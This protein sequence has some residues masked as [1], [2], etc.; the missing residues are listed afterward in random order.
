MIAVAFLA[1]IEADPSPAVWKER[2]SRALEGLARHHGRAM[3]MPV[4]A[5]DRFPECAGVL[6]DL[7]PAYPMA[8]ALAEVFYPIPVRAA[9]AWGEVILASDTPDADPLDAPA[10][11][12]AAELLY[13]VRKEDRLLLVQGESP[14]V[15]RL[16]NALALLLHREMSRWTER[17]CEIVRRYR[18]TGRQEAVARELGVSQQAVSG[19]LV[20]AGWP[21]LLE[22]EAALLEVCSRSARR[23]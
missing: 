10:F 13:R 23:P 1:E 11:L 17:Q 15:D 18:E 21:A 8:R 20:A 12:S 16:Q 4:A 5:A 9:A 14:P 22:A 19:S 2:L 3:L 7:T 6:A